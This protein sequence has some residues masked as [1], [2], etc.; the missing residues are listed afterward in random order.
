MPLDAKPGHILGGQK[1]RSSSAVPAA[2][3]AE[4]GLSYLKAWFQA[5]SR[6]RP[7]YLIPLT[8]LTAVYLSFELAFNA[9]LLDVSGGLV[10]QDE[11]NSIEHYGRVIS[12][13]AL[14]LGI[15]GMALM[16][17]GVK[18]HWSVLRWAAWLG[19]SAFLAILTMFY[20]EKW[21]IDGLVD[22][23]SG[24]ERR[25][26][27]QL[28]MLSHA[29]LTRD[30][31]VDGI[32]LSEREIATPEG[33][34][35]IALF[36]VLAF[37]TSN[38]AAKSDHVIES[39]IREK[40]AIVAGDPREL[41]NGPFRASVR[42]L[43]QSYNSYVDGVSEYYKAKDNIATQQSQAWDKYII[44]LDQRHWNPQRIPF[45]AVGRVRKEVQN[46]GVPVSDRWDPVDRQSFIGAVRAKA[47][48]E[49]DRRYGSAM[50]R[51]VGAVLPKD[52]SYG[53]FVLASSVQAK[54]HNALKLALSFRLWPQM[55]FKDYSSTIYEPVLDQAVA[56]RMQIYRDKDSEFDDAGPASKVGRDAM[57]AS[58]VPP[59]A[60]GFSLIGAMVHLGKLSLCLLRFGSQRLPL[61]RVIVIGPL[62]VL[63][64]CALLAPNP[65][66]TS[67]VFGYLRA[68]SHLQMGWFAERALT[69]VVQAQ[70]FGYPVN[71]WVRSNMLMGIAYGYHP[72]R[73]QNGRGPSHI[74]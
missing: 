12:G 65:I 23:S 66:T 2:F 55:T 14:A 51:E 33:K 25:A 62:T 3:L 10:T 37:S 50:E 30:V 24:T 53:D 57:E 32:D 31:E 64:L 29:I 69:W 60:L 5:F 68:Q 52:L 59:I 22:R 41:Y 8:L 54:W 18:E 42:Q 34:T 73:Q 27:V 16:P 74:S 56:E 49:A 19:G 43:N 38:L 58:L 15:W 39:I 71:E 67:R 11:V 35:F 26:A 48:E 9:R 63:M 21:L 70:P 7:V 45:Y 13:I 20:A 28:T 4:V 17:R 44:S 46:S 36:P 40:L 47:E 61:N 6:R 72:E 1:R